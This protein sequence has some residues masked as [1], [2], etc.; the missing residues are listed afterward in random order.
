MYHLNFVFPL[1][2]QVLAELMN[3]NFTLLNQSIHFDEKGDPKFGSF[4]IVFW[5]RSGEAQE[6]GFNYF[7][8]Q[9]HF[10]INSTA[11]EW[12]NGEVSTLHCS[13]III[14]PLLLHFM[15]C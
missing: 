11:I 1:C 5:N 9:V 4:S 10:S 13:R 12:Y 15:C 14:F 3:S 6:I 7:Y 8:P 2:Y